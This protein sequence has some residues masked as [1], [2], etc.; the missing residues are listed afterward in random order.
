MRRCPFL[1]ILFALVA[2]A[3]NPPPKVRFAR[4][5]TQTNVSPMGQGYVH[6]KKQSFDHKVFFLP[7]DETTRLTPLAALARFTQFEGFALETDEDRCGTTALVGAAI[8]KG[9]GAYCRLLEYGAANCRP[10][11]ASDKAVL[12][13]QAKKFPDELYSATFEDIGRGADSLLKCLGNMDDGHWAITSGK[14]YFAMKAMGI[15]PPGGSDENDITEMS[16]QDSNS[17]PCKISADDTGYG[18]HWIIFGKNNKGAHFVFDPMP[19]G[20]TNAEDPDTPQVFLMT[21]D[22]SDSFEKYWK[23]R[24]KDAGTGWAITNAK[25]AQEDIEAYAD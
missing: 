18:N 19:I 22:T 16:F 25:A 4:V 12:I 17:W 5:G 3:I 1:V 23:A 7:A 21:G 24:N 8:V 2:V 14:M 6:F 11:K 10:T 13:D 15:P 9:E 20:K